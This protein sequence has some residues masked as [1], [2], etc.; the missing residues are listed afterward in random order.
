MYDT[1]ALKLLKEDIGDKYDWRSVWNKI[2]QTSEYKLVKGG[3]GHIGGLRVSVTEKYV[4]IEGS[5]SKYFRGTNL[6]TLTLSQVEKVIKQLSRSL[7]VPV[8]KADV[9]RVDMA[10]NFEMSYPPEFYIAKMKS[11]GECCPNKWKETIYFPSNDVMLRLYNK[12]KEERRKRK[13]NSSTG[14]SSKNI[15]Q[16][17]L[18]YEICFSKKKMGRMF[19]CQLKAKDLY[20]K[21]VFWRFVAEWLYSYEKIGVIS[22]K[23]FDVSFEQIRTQSDFEDWCICV[24]NSVVGLSSFVKERFSVRERSLE[25]P[26]SSKIDRQDRQ[27]HKRI[28]DRIRGAIEHFG[29]AMEEMELM[30][31]LTDKIEAYLTEKFDNSPDAYD[32]R[33]DSTSVE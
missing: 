6:D 15:G 1:V 3:C 27:Y 17:L 28:Q 18:R 21:E 24:A 8:E 30:K 11:W 7:G 22:D 4:K 32:V 2:D 31:E 23:L 25:E 19:G 12:S 26:D 5:F 13:K 16:N 9:E 33:E 14:A 29:T 20:D 10:E